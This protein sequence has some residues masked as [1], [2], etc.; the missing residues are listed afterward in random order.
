MAFC[1]SCGA[2]IDGGARFCPKCGKPS[3]TAVAAASQ[4]VVPPPSP[5]AAA[6]VPQAQPVVTSGGGSSAL[7]I[8]LIVV[9]VIVGLGILGMGTAAFLIHRAVSRTH[10]R[11]HNGN[12]KVETPFGTVESSND[13]DDATQNLGLDVYPGASV[14]KGS[15]AN[16]TFGQT[17]TSAAEFETDD[18]PSAVA[19]FYKSKMPAATFM[20]S[21]T[22][23]YSLMAGGKGNLTT[24][25]IEPREG[26]TRIAISKIT[27]KAAN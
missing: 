8:I 13:A 14:V 20:S 2:V 5:M 25:N 22:N 26:K 11:E 7:K 1:N 24:V 3:A 6:P 18:P 19:E 4:G 10:V 27:G 16:V 23:H 9:A 17:H 21:E 15:T 12:V